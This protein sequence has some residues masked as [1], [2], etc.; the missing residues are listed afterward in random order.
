MFRVFVLGAGFSRY[1]GLPL[2]GELLDGVMC[3]SRAPGCDEGPLDDDLQ[4]FLRYRAECDGPQP[5]DRP[6]D[7]EDFASFLDIEHHLR[8]LGSRTWTEQ[9]N[10]S[11]ITIR[12]LLAE[13]IYELTASLSSEQLAPYIEFAK[14]LEPDDLVVTFNYDTI[15][16][17]AL[18]TVNSPY[19][20]FPLRN[21]AVD[22]SGATVDTSD[23]EI[24]LLKLHGSIDWFDKGTGAPA[25]PNPVFEN[26]H[27][28]RPRCVV[29]GPRQPDDPLLRVYRIENLGE[30]F[31]SCQTTF[32]APLILPPSYHK[33]LYGEVL[34]DFWYGFA[35]LGMYHRSACVVGLSLR[36][37][38][39]YVR[40]VVH[41]L[42]TNFQH[43]DRWIREDSR[44]RM[45]LV[46]Y[47]PD[48]QAEAEYRKAYRFVDWSKTDCCFEGF[49]PEA[50]DFLFAP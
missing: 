4:R 38:D 48:Q 40:Q 5:A 8:L 41:A 50:V 49:G 27:V 28:F 7:L 32:A 26:R 13:W 25:P 35:G 36:P 30:Y 31:R 11:Q 44:H 12:N 33:L 21:S 24:V 23:R 9:G 16:E 6:V 43:D 1:A 42:V 34:R 19:R 39:Q 45:K 10:Q 3:R 14:R 29:D 15:V 2:G 20:L 17:R 47:R 22:A 46:D 37:D 18:E